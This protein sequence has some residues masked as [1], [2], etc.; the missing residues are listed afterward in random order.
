AGDIIP[1][2]IAPVKSKR[3]GDE[4]KFKMPGKCPIC[5]SKAIRIEGEVVIRCT[6]GLYCPAQMSERLLHW[7]RRATLDIEGFGNEV[8]KDLLD[9]GIV[10]N[11]ADLYYLKKEDLLKIEHFAD[12]AAEN[13]YNAIEISKKRPLSK[14]LFALGIR[15]VGAYTASLLAK[16]FHSIDILSKTTYEQLES[17]HEIGPKVAGSIT[18]FFKEEHNLKVIERLRRAGFKMKEDLGGKKEKKLAGRTF[19]ITGTLKSFSRETAKEKI[20]ELGGRVAS[21]VSRK[22]DYVVVGK[23]PG[24]KAEKAKELGVKTIDEE[25]LLW[26]LK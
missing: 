24:T 25:E 6:G 20:Q 1:E 12:K 22:T 23:S 2:V 18:S 26:M 13:L 8:V 9:K 19:I 15:H 21:S 16:R 17:I 3:T 14:L 4:R 5:G 10:K 7:G 11:V